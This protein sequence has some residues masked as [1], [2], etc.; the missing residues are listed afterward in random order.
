MGN[1]QGRFAADF[2]KPG[3]VGFA[4]G[5]AQVRE[6]PPNRIIDQFLHQIGFVLR[7]KNL[8]VAEA[9]KRGRHPTDNRPRFVLR[10]AIVK[11][12]AHHGLAG[13]DQ[14]KRP[15]GRHAQV[16]HGLAAQEFA[17][18][19]AQNGQPV[20]GARIRRGSGPFELKGPVFALPVD[21]FPEVD[22]TAV[23]QLTG[24]VAKLVAPIAHG[25]RIHAV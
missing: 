15:R 10:V 12:V 5:I 21:D 13:R 25:K 23:A 3:Q 9:G 2:F 7:S 20:G 11:H 6:V 8:E 16:V 17:N 19:G 24:P 4:S 18:R 14:A 22:G 1:H